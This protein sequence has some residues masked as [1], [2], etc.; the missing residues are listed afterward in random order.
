[1]TTEK[2]RIR[3]NPGLPA[4]G[5][6]REARPSKIKKAAGLPAMGETASLLDFM[7]K[8]QSNMF[9]KANEAGLLGGIRQSPRNNDG[10]LNGLGKDQFRLRNEQEQLDRIKDSWAR[11]EALKMMKSDP[12][13]ARERAEEMLGRG[14]VNA[15]SD[16]SKVAT[17]A[18]VPAWESMFTQHGTAPTLN[19]GAAMQTLPEAASPAAAA[20]MSPSPPP[21]EKSFFERAVLPFLPGQAPQLAGQQAPSVSPAAVGARAGQAIAPEQPQTKSFSIIDWL[22]RNNPISGL[23]SMGNSWLGRNNPLDVIGNVNQNQQAALSWLGRNNPMDF[24]NQK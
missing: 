21:T 23:Q 8:G 2:S 18:A 24:F 1:M 15:P 7:Q 12:S 14:Q 3:K 17:A 11:T 6:T 9:D 13:I 5:E 20:V 22:T 19:D 10:G 16:Q 4:M